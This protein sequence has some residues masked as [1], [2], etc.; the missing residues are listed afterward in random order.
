M[1]NSV[2][3]W[4]MIG[5]NDVMR[6]EVILPITI[7]IVILS[8][9]VPNV[10]LRYYTC[11]LCYILMFSLASILSSPIILMRP[12]NV[13]N[14][15]IIGTALKHFSK[16]IG[17]KWELRNGKVLRKNQIAVIIA[18]HQSMLD[19]MGMFDILDDMGKF[20]VILKKELLYAIPFGPMAWL[21][22]L[23]FVDRNNRTV[24]RNNMNTA[25]NVMKKQKTKLWIYPEGTRNKEAK[26]ILPFKSG[27]FRIAIE[28]GVPIIPIVFSPYYFIDSKNKIFSKGTERRRNGMN[29]LIPSNRRNGNGPE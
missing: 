27:G 10:K 9:L 2:I 6:F 21:T 19:T 26:D 11:Y 15:R 4:C 28:L 8:P 14:I 12:R 3:S 29:S 18:N 16:V 5:V 7:I 20:T 17:I 23:V 1:A 13:D 24:A 22:G 25:A